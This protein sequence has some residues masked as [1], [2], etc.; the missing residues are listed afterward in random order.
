MIQ[1]RAQLLQLDPWLAFPQANCAFRFGIENRPLPVGA[2]FLLWDNLPDATGRCS[3]CCGE[4]YGW[5]FGGLLSVGGAVGCC[6]RCASRLTN[7]FG[8]LGIVAE[9]LNGVLRDTEFHITTGLFGGSVDGPRQP[10]C[11]ALRRLGATDLPSK[12]WAAGEDRSEV[13][14][15][16][17]TGPSRKRRTR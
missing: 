11:Y 12:E 17:D 10:L 5:G 4:V 3:H 8:G 14:L 15:S 1:F 7:R 2:L 16:V 9:R 13:S 6:V